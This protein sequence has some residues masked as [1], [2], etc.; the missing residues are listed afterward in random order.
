M[1]KTVIHMKNE[2]IAA[3]DLDQLNHGLF[4]AY[5]DAGGLN[6]PCSGVVVRD[7]RKKR[8]LPVF[9]DEIDPDEG[10][11]YDAVV[12]DMPGGSMESLGDVLGN[13][14]ILFETMREIGYEPVFCTAITPYVQSTLAVKASLDFAGSNVLH[15]V[16]KNLFF[17]EDYLEQAGV[18]SFFFFDGELSAEY[19]SLANR[20]EREGGTVVN[21]HPI[22]R[23]TSPL[24]EHYRLKYRESTIREITG[25]LRGYTR[26]SRLNMQEWLEKM[27]ME[28]S[29][30]LDWVET[31]AEGRRPLFI[32]A[33]NKGGVGKSA[34]AKVLLDYL[35]YE[36]TPRFVRNVSNAEPRRG[37]SSPPKDD[38]I[39]ALFG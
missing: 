30:L 6:T 23:F 39:E 13:P 36:W 5:A 1:H 25:N 26:T 15:V 8:N 3:F 18:S 21:L 38:A 34:F 33:S 16:V 9:V 2:K 32:V 17:A 10:F 24:L 14:A 7:I 37:E 22:C 35:R 29:A 4:G 12:F 19:G 31:R 28:I 20:L 27:D 11:D